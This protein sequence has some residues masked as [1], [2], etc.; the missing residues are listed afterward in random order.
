VTTDHDLVEAVPWDP[1]AVELDDDRDR[2][3]LR[4]RYYG[5]MQELRVLVTGAQVLVAFLLTAPFAERFRLLDRWGDRLYGIALVC[6]ILAAVCFMA[7]TA[8]HRIGRRQARV[9]R[10]RAAILTTRAGLAFLAVSL[11]SGLV[12]V[13]RLVF[14]DRVAIVLAAVV[15]TVMVTLWV[16]G[17]LASRY[18]AHEVP[19]DA[20]RERG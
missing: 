2:E 17:P 5:L 16:V 10:L 7:P 6:G 20:P 19:V 14:D 12:L 9:G 4:V 13:T 15:G 18:L 8:F 11:L 1:S 3:E